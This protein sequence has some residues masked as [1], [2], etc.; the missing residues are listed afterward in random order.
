MLLILLFLIIVWGLRWCTCFLKV[1][2]RVTSSQPM[3][4][5]SDR[6]A[7]R[8]LTSK[9][10]NTTYPATIQLRSACLLSGLSSSM[11]RANSRF[12]IT[13]SFMKNW[14]LGTWVTRLTSLAECRTRL[15]IV[16]V[17]G[18]AC[19][20]FHC[21]ESNCTSSRRECIWSYRTFVWLLVGCNEDLRHFSK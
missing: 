13:S 1:T 10:N 15:N 6:N 12:R 11:L 8:R 7:P 18:R 2:A 4:I 17:F 5:N 19:V 14:S 21:T 9:E 3:I 16:Q 20:N